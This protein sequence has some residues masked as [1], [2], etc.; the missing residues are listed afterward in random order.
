MPDIVTEVK[1]WTWEQYKAAENALAVQK[2]ACNGCGVSTVL[3]TAYMA[4]LHKEGT[5]KANSSAPVRLMLH[6]LAHLAGGEFVLAES[7]RDW[8]YAAVKECERIVSEYEVK[9]GR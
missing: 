1:N 9:H 2:G 4:W 8:Y 6:Q 5:D 3:T 7:D